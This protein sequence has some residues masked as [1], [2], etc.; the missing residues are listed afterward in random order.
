M[1]SDL[2]LKVECGPAGPIWE[3]VVAGP[4]PENHESIFDSAFFLVIPRVTLNLG[5]P[6]SRSVGLRK[7]ASLKN[8]L[9][10]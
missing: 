2:I 9:L 5:P 7:M 1:K 3:K 4:L 8:L 10:R 6:V